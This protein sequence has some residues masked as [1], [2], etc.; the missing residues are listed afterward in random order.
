MLTC[1]LKRKK[2]Q[3]ALLF[4]LH[5]ESV[6]VIVKNSTAVIVKKQNY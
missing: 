3:I 1:H 6:A 5:R 4:I 2:E